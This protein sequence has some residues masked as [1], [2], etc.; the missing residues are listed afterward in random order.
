MP[1]HRSTEVVDVAIIGCGPAGATLANLLGAHGWTVLV[2]ER[3]AQVYPLPRAI[4]F[5]GEVMRVFET[6]GLRA[7]VAAVSRPGI[8][9]M[10]FVNAAGETLL[11]R[12]GGTDPGPHGC[13]S[14]HYFHQPEL[15][16]VLRQ[17]LQRFDRVQLL[18]QHE[19]TAIKVDPVPAGA[20]SPGPAR[21]QVTDLASGAAQV[22][23]ARWVV[24]CDGARS[25][26][27]R[28]LGSAVADLGLHQPWLVFDLRLKTD[29]PGLPDHTV[30]HC[31]PARPMIFCNVS[32]N[33]RCWEIML[34]PGDDPA[35]LV[36]PERIW[37]LISRW[38]GPA[39]ADIERTVI[40]T[41][42]TVIARGWR[43]GPLLLAG[44]W[45]AQR[46]YYARIRKAGYYLSN[47][48]LEPQLA[49]LAAPLLH[50]D[51]R[52]AGALSLVTTGLKRVLA[53]KPKRVAPLVWRQGQRRFVPLPLSSATRRLRWHDGLAL[54]RS[55]P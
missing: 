35:E 2:F 6:A 53:A 49:A 3:D 5:D 19:V 50:G 38:I 33:R 52:V 51:G 15:E 24:G 34:M 25:L 32:G 4:H 9:G 39:Q 28:S 30:Q 20:G 46:R 44:D 22:Q 27:R 41:F 55:P 8:K 16:Q 11:M 18:S 36:K 7:A 29:L 37:P 17:G 45:P 26:V 23:G 14:S 31:G 47:G 40:Y 12:S 42:H 43:R 13:A 48:E 10:H 1:L 21:L 54:I